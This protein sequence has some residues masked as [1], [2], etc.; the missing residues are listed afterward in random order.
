M[1][2]MSV[3]CTNFNIHIEQEFATALAQMLLFMTLNEYLSSL[4]WIH[5]VLFVKKLALIMAKI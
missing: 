3:N 4:Q 1:E 5:I 2:S